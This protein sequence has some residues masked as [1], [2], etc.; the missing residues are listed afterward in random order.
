MAW[1]MVASAAVSVVGGALMAPDQPAQ[2]SSGGGF[3]GPNTTQA[4]NLWSSAAN[5]GSRISADAYKNTNQSYLDSLNRSNAIN[6]KPLQVEANRVGAGYNQL[7]ADSW[8]RGDA[9]NSA[10]NAAFGQQQ[11]MY[12]ASNQVLK[13]AFDPQQALYNQTQQNLQGQVNAGQA[14]R[15]LGNSAVG[16][17]EYNNAM[18]NFG[19]QWQAQQLAN[20]AQGI[21]AAANAN[22]SGGQ[23]A[24]LGSGLAND[25]SNMQNLAY[26]YY[27]QG[28]QLPISIQQM[29]AGM[30]GQNANTYNQGMNNLQGM[31]NNVM[32]GTIP[33]ITGGQGAQQFNTG[34]NTQNNAAL[35]NLGTQLF[36]QAGKY[37]GNQGS[38]T[39]YDYSSP[40]QSAGN[41]GSSSPGSYSSGNLFGGGSSG[42]GG[43]LDYYS[44]SGG[45]S[46]GFGF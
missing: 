9:Q 23:Q 43:I 15:G 6:Y 21:N 8:H 38:G 27:M 28:K 30:P 12:D 39:M 14:M 2:G 44:G 4:N 36:G 10:A 20:Q 34:Q 5:R 37:F 11:P 35:A 42:G 33:Y 19:T 26:Q 17:Q 46:S 1:G 29:I 13:T 3:S 22:S 18:S 16:A 7:G 41:L 32:S 24:Q 31:Q 45:G 25:A 40:T